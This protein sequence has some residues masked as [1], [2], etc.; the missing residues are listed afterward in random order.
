[1]MIYDTHKR[2]MTD[3]ENGDFMLLQRADHNQHEWSVNLYDQ[4][5]QPL[6]ASVVQVQN[7]DEFGNSGRA[8]LTRC[9]LQKIWIPTG[10]PEPP[11]YFDEAHPQIPRLA[12]FLEA[13]LH[14]RGAKTPAP[15]FEFIDGRRNDQRAEA[16]AW[17]NGY[18]QTAPAAG[19]PDRPNPASGRGVLG[20]LLLTLLFHLLQVLWVPLVNLNGKFA[21]AFLFIGFTQLL[22]MLPAIHLARRDN[23]RGA[24]IGLIIGTSLTFLVGLP[25][26]GLGLM[27]APLITR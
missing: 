14:A 18:Q 26:A 1:M 8:T 17:A 23:H 3:A 21:L 9:V 6:L 15:R 24:M 20:G 11:T 22:Y 5:D 10:H 16:F 19:L 25:L 13:R 12:A 27:C 7:L 4:Y 2:R